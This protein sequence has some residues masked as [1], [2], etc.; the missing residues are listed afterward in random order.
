MT[1]KQR[2]R[3][4]MQGGI[5]DRVPT[6]PQIC[7][8]HAIRMLGRPFRETLIEVLRKP[9]LMNQLVLDCAR[10]YG[11][12]GIRAFVLAH[13]M[14][15]EEEA[16]KAYQVGPDGRRTGRVD[17]Q[18]GGWPI[19]LKEE[20]HIRSDTDLERIE[21][22][23]VEGLLQSP[24]FRALQGIIR[25]AGDDLFVAS[26]PD[27]FTVEYVAGQR[28]KEQAMCDLVESPDFVKR[29]IDKA[30]DIVI[31]RSVALCKIGVDALYLGETYG[32]L[33]G[34]RQ[35]E[36]FC[37]P[38]IRRLVEAV[39]PYDVL[40]YLHICGNSTRLFELMADTGVDCIEPLD[41]LGGVQVADAKRR[42]G[43][44][45]ALMGGVNTVTLASG[46]FEET[47]VDIE[48]CIRE[49]ANGGGYILATG[50]MLPTETSPE[51]VRA[52]VEMARDL[53]KY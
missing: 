35:F 17:F 29:I 1:G 16:G 28:G 24:A 18:G 8:P 11:V 42:V 45:V 2:M 33:I 34:P 31:R 22:P 7:H 41:P 50:D 53:G 43:S 49:G 36:E 39:R 25:Q 15:I 4:A 46:T 6:M 26:N 19:P 21:I 20:I 12:D 51:K 40:T 5:P 52:M 14:R 47:V 30:T 37:A 10:R 48:R 38:Y 32:G 13:P 3:V 44:R 27:A 23:S 9:E